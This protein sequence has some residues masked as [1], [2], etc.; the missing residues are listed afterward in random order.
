M[1]LFD[2]NKNKIYSLGEAKKLLQTKK[3]ER[4]TTIPVGDGYRL[5]P[6]EQTIRNDKFNGISYT[7]IK[8]QNFLNNIDARR[9]LIEQNDES[10]IPIYN[11][12]QSVKKYN[13]NQGIAR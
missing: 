12:Y 1:G 4:Y 8:R 9:E 3:Y 5:V 10:D 11:N 7:K 6:M 2:R 13:Q